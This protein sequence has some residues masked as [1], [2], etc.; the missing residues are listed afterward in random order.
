MNADQLALISC[1]ASLAAPGGRVRLAALRQ[2][3]WLSRAE[4]DRAALALEASG[5]L[6]LYPL[7]DPI[8]ITPADEAAI[9][10]NAAGFARHICYL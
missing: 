3:C 1:A 7:D 2:A 6:I 10:R 9:L 5:R 8:E 4:F